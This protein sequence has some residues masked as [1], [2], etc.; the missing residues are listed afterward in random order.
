VAGDRHF[1]PRARNSLLRPDQE[2]GADGAHE[3]SPVQRLLLPYA[4]G[5]ECLVLSS[6]TRAIVSLCLDLKRSR[7]ATE[8]AEMP[9]ISVLD[10]AKAPFSRQKLR[11][12]L[13]QPVVRA[14]G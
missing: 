3:F 8:S 11:A 2:G 12:S 1:R 10:R 6:E 7:A 9:T 4:I 5:F 13:V 14:R